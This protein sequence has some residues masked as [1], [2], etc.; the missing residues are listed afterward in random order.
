MPSVA[1]G[2]RK[3]SKN[4]ITQMSKGYAYQYEEYQSEYQQKDSCIEWSF[5]LDHLPDRKRPESARYLHVK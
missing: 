3:P 2:A 1:E 5:T 4:K